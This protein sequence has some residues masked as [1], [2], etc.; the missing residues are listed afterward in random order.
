[1]VN[2]GADAVTTPRPILGRRLTVIGLTGSTP[3]RS[4]GGKA[5]NRRLLTLG[6][7]A[8]GA[9]HEP[10]SECRLATF[11]HYRLNGPET[12]GYQTQF[13]IFPSSQLAHWAIQ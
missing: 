8:A 7:A 12:M 13:P 3:V 10:L 4:T 11:L 1:V 5:E 6:G 9:A 2:L